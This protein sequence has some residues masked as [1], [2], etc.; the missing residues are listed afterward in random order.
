M[1]LPYRNNYYKQTRI[2][3]SLKPTF[4]KYNST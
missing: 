1:R 4:M 2:G 3:H